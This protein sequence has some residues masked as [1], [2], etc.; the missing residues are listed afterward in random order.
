MELFNQ[1]NFLHALGW[2]LFDSLWQLGLLWMLYKLILFVR[3]SLKAAQRH[4]LA[5]LV[6]LGGTLWFLAN[7]IYHWNYSE[8]IPTLRLLISGTWGVHLNESWLNGWEQALPYLSSLYLI[9]LSFLL[10]Q[11][12]S[13]YRFTKKIKASGLVKLS[14]ELRVFVQTMAQRLG[15][16]RPVYA[17][18]SELIDTPLTI[19]F[20][21]PVVLLP[22][23][24]LNNL[25]LRQAET[26]I[27][28]EL[29]HIRRND[30]LINL[31]IAFAEI[32]L[33]FNPFAR[34]LA[35]VLRKE[36]EHCCDDLVLQFKYQPTEYAQAL[37]ALEQSRNGVTSLVLAA[38]GK[39]RPILLQRI[40]RMLY[41]EK[42]PAV[43]GCRLCGLLLSALLLGSV[44]LIVNKAKSTYSPD[45]YSG[46]SLHLTN[47]RPPFFTKSSNEVAYNA[48]IPAR[49][50]RKKH[51]SAATTPHSQGKTRMT[52]ENNAPVALSVDMPSTMAVTQPGLITSESEVLPIVNNSDQPVLVFASN[53][54]D[55][56]FTFRPTEA[57]AAVE[58]A[59]DRPYVPSGSFSIQY[60][61]EPAN[62][63]EVVAQLSERKAAN[64]ILKEMLALRLQQR[65][66]KQQLSR[67]QESIDKALNQLQ[68]RIARNAGI[69]GKQVQ[70]DWQEWL[71]AHPGFSQALSTEWELLKR[72]NRLESL[73]VI[74]WESLLR[75]IQEQSGPSASF[76]QAEQ[77]VKA[78]ERN[79]KH[80][81]NT[82]IRKIVIL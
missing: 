38:T 54:Q 81:A 80:P 53:K 27:L 8:S 25:S 23:A 62:A 78:T 14:G 40:R 5:L 33:F 60:M 71:L 39:S 59:T 72:W 43:L 58:A 50:T 16:R 46:L 45:P 32:L 31:L 15:I 64:L 57:S 17:W 68:L 66:Q 76:E 9:A 75:K 6:L 7:I 63:N 21:K 52:E 12:Y 82:G 1:S 30:F 44:S 26:I 10:A 61:S 47:N 41:Q 22:V 34:L 3:P 36:R 55:I 77:S 37:L 11:L 4:T 51:E 20:W 70:T 28:H 35:D 73:P 65:N 13:Q 56:A 49:A 42:A 24:L 2:S 48:D 69:D 67:T 74:E 79:S 18:V 29:N 19:G